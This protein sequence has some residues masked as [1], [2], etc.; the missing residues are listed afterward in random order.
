MTIRQARQTKSFLYRFYPP[1]RATLYFLGLLTG[2]AAVTFAWIQDIGG[3]GDFFDYLNQF[4]HSAR[5]WFEAPSPWSGWIL[6]VTALAVTGI[7]TRI[8]PQP[9]LWS[10]FLLVTLLLTLIVRYILWRSL[11][12]LNLADPLNGVISIILFAM[13]ML[14]TVGYALQLFFMLRERDRRREADLYA[15]AV[16]AG[17]Y[18]PTVDVLIPTYNEPAIVLRR[19]I[20][21]CQAMDYPHK[22]VYL[23]DDGDR[24]EIRQLAKELGCH[25]IARP[26]HRYAKAGNL[27]YAIARTGGELITVFDADFV[28]TRNFLNRTVGFFQA[29]TIGMVQT[30]QCFYNSDAPARNLGLE[31]ELTHEV[32]IF[33]RHYQLIRDGAD[34]VLCYGSSFVMRRSA[35]E[36]VGG[37]VTNTLSEDYFT[38]VR[39]SAQGYQI[40]YLDENLSAG[41]VPEDMGSHISQRQRWAHGTLQAFFI[42]ASPLTIR[43]LTLRQR[44]AHLEGICQWFTSICRVAFLIVPIATAFLDIIPVTSSISEWLY[45]FLPLYLV[46]LTSFAWF[47]H[48]SRPALISDVYSVIQC[49]PL[50]ATVLQTLIRPFSRGF[51]VTPKGTTTT[52]S[53]FQWQLAAPLVIIWVL[54]LLAFVTQIFHLLMEPI[55]PMRSELAQYTQVGVVWT[56]YNL[57]VIGIAILSFIDLPKP[58][59]YEWF[60]Q[61]Q[62]AELICDGKSIPGIATRI[63]EIGAEIVFPNVSESANWEQ[64][65]SV[66]FVLPEEELHL[67]ARILRIEP[68]SSWIKVRLAFTEV[69]SQQHRHLIEMLFCKPGQW[70]RKVSPGELQMLWLLVRSLVRPRIWMKQQQLPEFQWSQLPSEHV[71]IAK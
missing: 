9:K 48:R 62:S 61:S 57:V 50:T 8:S 23:L 67:S 68:G 15:V 11:S 40:A 5:F 30:H 17:V 13:E 42:K 56:G 65:Q 16:E 19:T 33:S 31:K 25:Y 6:S 1:Q 44:I 20:V 39:I 29:P 38:G 64:K 26:F 53:N 60:E 28:P 43:G 18:A 59:A 32:E 52:R 51:R 12:T 37:F 69:S 58:H 63:S 3:A 21:G 4:Q 24:E 49:F 7:I 71:T 54:T 2:L 22:Q 27:N 35:L 45:F 70:K 34:S 10:R 46:Q 36:R 55:H 47:N 14:F 66:R 41:L